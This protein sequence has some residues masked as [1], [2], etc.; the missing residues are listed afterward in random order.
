MGAVAPLDAQY[1]PQ[2][3]MAR[4]AT[5]AKPAVPAP[6]I[7]LPDYALSHKLRAIVRTLDDPDELMPDRAL[8]AR[9]AANDLKVGGA[10]AGIGNTDGRFPLARDKF[11]VVNRHVSR[12]YAERFH[13]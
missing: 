1:G 2:R 9:V 10:Y 8:K 11:D 7:Y 4:I 13:L 5:Q 12:I 3:A 6:R